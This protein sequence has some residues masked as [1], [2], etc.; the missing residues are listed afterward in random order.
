MDGVVGG[1]WVEVVEVTGAIAMK[2]LALVCRSLI[3]KPNG[4]NSMEQELSVEKRRMEIRFFT[5][6]G[7]IR[8]L[9]SEKL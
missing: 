7:T 6:L 3:E 5:R 4:S 9:L 2:I 8:T 1:L